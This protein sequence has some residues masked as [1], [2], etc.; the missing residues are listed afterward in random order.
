MAVM[1]FMA[2][3]LLDRL[4]HGTFRNA[5]S[6]QGLLGPE[7]RVCR[8]LFDVHFVSKNRAAA[9]EVAKTAEMLEDKGANRSRNAEKLCITLTNRRARRATSAFVLE[10]LSGHH[11]QMLEGELR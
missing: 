11:P 9:E 1:S 2:V 3:L 5:K 4:R 10:P 7:P 8:G 6:P